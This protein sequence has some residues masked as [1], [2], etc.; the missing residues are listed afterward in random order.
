MG[1]PMDMGLMLQRSYRGLG[2]D[3]PYQD[4]AIDLER[5]LDQPGVDNEVQIGERTPTTH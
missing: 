2:H 5:G 3:N 4:V 1:M